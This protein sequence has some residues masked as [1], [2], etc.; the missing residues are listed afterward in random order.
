MAIT[1][2]SRYTSD[3]VTRVVENDVSRT[4]I[5][6]R[7]ERART[8]DFT[9]YQWLD[10]DRIDSVARDYFDDERQWYHIAD[11]NPEILVW[12]EVAPGTVIRIPNG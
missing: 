8:F 11:A 10:G 3:K 2:N 7:P 1:L 5:V 12:T 6:K 4:V 9:F